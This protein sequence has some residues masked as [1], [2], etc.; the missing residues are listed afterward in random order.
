MME[1]ED[2]IEEAR[3]HME[4]FDTHVAS[5]LSQS[6][7]HHE[8]ASKVETLAETWQ[9]V[10]R[11]LTA[12]LSAKD[13]EIRHLKH[14]LEKTEFEKTSAENF[15]KGLRDELRVV[16]SSL[17][18]LRGNVM[19][20]SL[21]DGN[22]SEVKSLKLAEQSTEQTSLPLQGLAEGGGLGLL[23]SAKG[24]GLTPD[25]GKIP[26][27]EELPCSTEPACSEELPCSTEP[28]CSEELPCS[29]EE[30]TAGHTLQT[31]MELGQEGVLHSKE[32]GTPTLK[33]G[34]EPETDGIASQHGIGAV[35]ASTQNP[36]EAESGLHCSD[37]QVPG[38]EAGMDV[39]E[40][41]PGSQ[42]VPC[43]FY[44]SH[45]WNYV[46]LSPLPPPSKWYGGCIVRLPED[47]VCNTLLPQENRIL[48]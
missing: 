17:A 26:E 27:Q 3:S 39:Q 48:L 21:Q 6:K 33:T 47:R 16:T 35:N 9:D 28:A 32:Q 46:V 13:G 18:Q 19:E 29:E 20:T 40:P 42:P 4:S 34:M 1:G 31:G 12:V 37:S 43:R 23:P 7:D 30:G 8:L 41:A 36:E 24:K 38:Q 14:T 44:T 15:S 2:A 45:T 22:S 11:V 10:K 5:L 25:Q